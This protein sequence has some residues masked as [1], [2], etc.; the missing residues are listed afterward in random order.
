MLLAPVVLAAVLGQCQ[1]P[2]SRSGPPPCAAAA[3]PGCLPGY[4]RRVDANGRVFYSCDREHVAP[5][6]ER[7]LEATF[8]DPPP[9]IR[10]A[11]PQRPPFPSVDN[12]AR[13]SLGLVFTPGATS[14]DRAHTAQATG[15]VALELRG[16]YG[17]SRLRLGYEFSSLSHQ[18]EVSIKYDFFDR[19]ALRPFVAVGGGAGYLEQDPGWRPTG[20]VSAGLDVYV[21]RDVFATF[22]VKE[23]AFLH[24]SQGIAFSN[25]HLWS[26]FGGLGFFL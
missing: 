25:V 14:P 5:G 2:P 15:A 26:A 6:S 1:E 13:G 3:V 7:T 11:A 18:A 9:R 4:Q 16:P 22:E 19:A 8:A 24:T 21:T 20:S 10:S 17:G 12:E 23:R